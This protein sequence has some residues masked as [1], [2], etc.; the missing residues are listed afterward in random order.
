M[1]DP[2][3]AYSVRLT[4]SMARLSKAYGNGNLSSGIRLLIKKYAKK[5]NGEE[6]R[7]APEMNSNQINSVEK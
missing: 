7:K 6:R 4:L 1:D 2:K 3:K 5:W